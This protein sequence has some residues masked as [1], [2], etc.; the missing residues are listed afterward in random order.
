MY[1]RQT[2]RVVGSRRSLDHVVVL[3]RARGCTRALVD[4][5]GE[6]TYHHFVVVHCE[7]LRCAVRDSLD[8]WLLL[9]I[10]LRGS[11]HGR[12]GAIHAIETGRE[13]VF[14]SFLAGQIDVMLLV[15]H[16]LGHHL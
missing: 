7:T 11:V 9:M 13:R 5:A 2:Q 14:L 15:S 8:V 6:A 16:L 12:A 1:K 10:A 3:I 4:G